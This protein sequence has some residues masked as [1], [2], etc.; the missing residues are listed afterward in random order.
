MDLVDLIESR[1]F[2]GSEFLLW[3]WFRSECFEAQLEIE[4]VGPIEC[5]MD[6][7][8]TL[9]A[10]LAETERND[11]KGGAPAHSP[12]AKLALRRGKRVAKAKLGLIKEGREFGL[13]LKAPTLDISGAQL[14]ALLSRDEEEQF[15]ER[16]QLLEELE[17]IIGALYAEFIAARLSDRWHAE[18][19][20]ALKRWSAAEAA[21]RSMYPGPS[22]ASDRGAAE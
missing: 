14:P 8:L 22:G 9:E 18:F 17:E 10:N 11:F 6:D 1:R 20:P 4:G 15:Y 16:M 5:W 12:E 3:L 19:V 2:L 21:E 7:A 13:T